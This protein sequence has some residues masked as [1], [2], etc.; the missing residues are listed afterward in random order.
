MEITESGI[1]R[2]GLND[3]GVIVEGATLY[4][5]TEQGFKILEFASYSGMDIDDDE[6][7]HARLDY[8]LDD[9]NLGYSFFEDL[10][11]AVEEAVEFLNTHCCEDGVAFTFRDTDFVLIG[12]NEFE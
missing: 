3:R 5:P 11:W 9:G 7:Q 10:G 4:N 1:I 6:V 12:M 8:E 2:Y